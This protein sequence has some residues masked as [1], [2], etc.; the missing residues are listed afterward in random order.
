[1]LGHRGLQLFEAIKPLTLRIH[2]AQACQQRLQ[3]TRAA[4]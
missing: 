2:L 3:A 1:V 4:Q